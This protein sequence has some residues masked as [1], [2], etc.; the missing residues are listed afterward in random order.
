MT[1]KRDYYQVLGVNRDVDAAGLKSAYRK[2]AMQY[3]PDRNPGDKVAEEKF[4]EASEAYEVLADSQKRAVYDRYGHEGL[5]GQGYSGFR[6]VSDVFSGFGSI[7]ED[8]FGFGVGGA[9]GRG[10][11]RHRGRDLR[12]DLSI[13][14]EEAMTGADREI[15]FDRHGVCKRCK[16]SQ[17]EPGTSPEVCRT[18]GGTGQL[19]RQQG[20]FSLATP[21]HVCRGSGQKVVSPCKDCRGQGSVVEHRKMSVK[22]PPGVDSGLRLR[23]GGEGEASEHGGPPGDL[24][25]FLTVEVSDR[26]RREGEDL[27]LEHGVNLAQA[28]LGCRV[29]IPTLE[30]DRTLEIA[31]GTQPGATLTIPGA[32]V[33]RLKGGGRGDLHVV[34]NVVVP[35]KLTKRQRELLEELAQSMGDSV[36]PEVPSSFFQ[37]LFSD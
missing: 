36:Q 12:Y 23:V 16:G 5:S 15:E 6:D 17:S 35:K 21:C 27:Y 29:Q 19:R 31:A 10:R 22:I 13:S 7:F 8:I 32:G 37:R 26:F 1:T 33:P 24:Y 14:F 11:Q 34:V 20:F 3:H 9:E 28:A 25:V 30:G 4:K 2:A 18:C